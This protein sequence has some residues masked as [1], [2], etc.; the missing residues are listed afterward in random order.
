LRMS[1]A[2]S[3]PVPVYIG[4]H[5]DAGLRRAARIGDGWTSAMITFDDLR[6]TIDLLHKLRTEYGRAGAPFEIQAVCLDRFGL[7]GYRQQADLGVT[8]AIVMPWVFDGV[9]F[10][11]PLQSKK[12]SLRRFADEIMARL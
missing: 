12:D 2:P 9:P 3:E 11:G 4:G 8:D 6:D 1:P 10:D 5:S 7:D